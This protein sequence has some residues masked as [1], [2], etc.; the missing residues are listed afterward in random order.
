MRAP[1]VVSSHRGAFWLGS[2]SQDVLFILAQAE[3]SSPKIS[4]V[5]KSPLAQ[6]KGNAYRT[7]SPSVDVFRALQAIRESFR[8]SP[9]GLSP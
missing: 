9:P 8:L 3:G 6:L 1:V 7:E 2:G 4:C 5:K